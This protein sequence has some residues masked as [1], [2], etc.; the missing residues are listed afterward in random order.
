MAQ[1][2]LSPAQSVVADLH[3]MWP[4]LFGCLESAVATAVEDFQRRDRTV[5]P[6]HLASG[7]RNEL[8]WRLQESGLQ[9]CRVANLSNN[10]VLFEYAGYHLRALKMR[11][12]GGVPDQGRSAAFQNY[13]EQLP[14]LP[15][16]TEGFLSPSALK[17]MLLWKYDKETRSLGSLFLWLPNEWLVEIPHPASAQQ[18]APLAIDESELVALDLIDEG[19]DENQVG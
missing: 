11:E 7:V 2:T 5:E 1:T 17:L 3:D 8:F 12:E 13:C 9:E 16:G 6:F 18:A 15:D 14:L 19:V 10:G 4:T